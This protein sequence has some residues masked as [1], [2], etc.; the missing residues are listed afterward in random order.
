[1]ARAESNKDALR[2]SSSREKAGTS[3]VNYMSGQFPYWQGS[4]ENA[5]AGHT[6]Q[7]V[8]AAGASAPSCLS[9]S[10]S[11]SLTHIHAFP[12]HSP[13]TPTHPLHSK[14]VHLARLST[15]C[16]AFSLI[17]A[18]SGQPPC[19]ACLPASPT[20]ALRE[21]QVWA[22]SWL[23]FCFPP[24]GSPPHP[25]PPVA[26]VLLLHFCLLP[27]PPPPTILAPSWH[28]GYP[29]PVLRHVAAYNNCQRVCASERGHPGQHHRTEKAGG[30]G[31]IQQ[32]GPDHLSVVL[33][34]FLLPT[35]WCISG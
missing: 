7:S 4:L 3:Q 12:Q 17:G 14:P 33:W 22:L 28:V 29:W 19:T 8:R 5:E 34:T 16:G 11:L 26:R 35:W 18:T 9:L 15:S 20:P 32:P 24:R 25:L 13:C 23:L 6:L 10:L 31:D 27:R 21:E 2:L 1:M 30:R